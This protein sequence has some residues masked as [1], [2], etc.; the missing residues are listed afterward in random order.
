METVRIRDGKKSDPGSR[1]KS[2]IRNTGD[3]D[4]GQTFHAD[5]DPDGFRSGSFSK[6]Y[7]SRKIRNKFQL[8]FTALPVYIVSSFTSAS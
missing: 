1:I 2:R 6:F 3:D 8:L 7:T 5:A 4:P